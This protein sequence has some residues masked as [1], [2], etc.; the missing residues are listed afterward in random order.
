MTK[1]VDSRSTC[2]VPHKKARARLQKRVC[3]QG[4]CIIIGVSLSQAL[5][6]C[7]SNKNIVPN[8]L[9]SPPEGYGF[10]ENMVA[11]VSSPPSLSLDL[12]RC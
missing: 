3:A 11:S 7:A 2:M 1:E 8:S 4:T 10:E 9:P 12:N 5:V 6:E